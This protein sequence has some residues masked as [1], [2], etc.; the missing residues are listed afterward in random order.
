MNTV[1]LW[2]KV[3]LVLVIVLL[4]SSFHGYGKK[5]AFGKGN[6]TVYDAYKTDKNQKNMDAAQSNEKTNSLVPQLIKFVFSFAGIIILLLLLLK[7]LK[8]KSKQIY[9]QGPFYAM[10]GHSLGGNRSLQLIMI[11]KTLHILGIGNEVQLLRTVESGE[12]QDYI[13]QSLVEDTARKQKTALFSFKK[14]NAN[15]QAADWEQTFL[16]Q[17][18]Q[19]NQSSIPINKLKD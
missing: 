7:F 19:V 8:S 1:H 11:G 17:M 14:K 5:V 15:N 2:K 12:E 3:T 13:L 16:S 18:N 6:D 10:G 4:T 9:S